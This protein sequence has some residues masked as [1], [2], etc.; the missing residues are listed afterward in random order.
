MAQRV[1]SIDIREDLITAVLVSLGKGGATVQDSAIV[2]PEEDDIDTGVTEVLTH[3]EGKGALCRV[4]FGPEYFY[5]RNLSLPFTDKRKI[6]KILPSELEETIALD[7][8]ELEVDSLVIDRNGP[9]SSIIAALA[10]KEFLAARLAHLKELGLDPEIIGISGVQCALQF[11]ERIPETDCILL[12]CGC[13]RV[14]LFAM[15]GGK[16]QLLRSFSYD[17]ESLAKFHIDRNTAFASAQRPQ[18]LAKVVALLAGE[19]R[20]TLY[21]LDDIDGDIPFYLIGPIRDIP[22]VKEQLALALENRVEACE[23]ID[24]G[25]RL[26]V[27]CG[28]W[29]SDIMSSALALALKRGRR[30]P[31]FNFRKGDF[32]RKASVE[33][34]KFFAPRLGIPLLLC[35]VCFIGYSWHEYS[36]KEHEYMLLRQQA[37]DVFSETLPGVK[38]IVDPVQQ[39]KAKVQDLK[40][41]MLDEVGSGEVRSLDVLA[42]ISRLVP[43]SIN[44]HDPDGRSCTALA[45]SN[46][47]YGA[48]GV[49]CK[50]SFKCGPH[51]ANID[52]VV[53]HIDAIVGGDCH[54]DAGLLWACG[55][56]GRGSVDFDTCFLDKG[57]GDQKEDEQDEHH[58]DEGGHVEFGAL[59][60][61]LASSSNIYHDRIPWKC[62]FFFGSETVRRAERGSAVLRS[63][64]FRE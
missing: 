59:I 39:L 4:S 50:T 10:E 21:T 27:A 55:R 63:W 60:A 9:E 41:G 8:T 14:T 28:L 26:Q 52:F 45:I 42:E 35:L 33:R 38:R 31:G 48:I 57:G 51:R 37:R 40:K 19:V 6:E 32:A 5:Y 13:T 23:F 16:M 44:V 11:A 56:R 64:R 1:L 25:S 53:V 15:L 58:V 46:D 12:D 36:Q 34:I 61:S 17:N 24:E 62:W 47:H 2:V 49:F 43:T 54:K 22:E 30:Q 29:R 7:M 18:A 20:R 3:L